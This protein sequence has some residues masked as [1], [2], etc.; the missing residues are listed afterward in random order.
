[1]DLRGVN[2]TALHHPIDHLRAFFSA[3]IWD[4]RPAEL[5]RAKAALFRVSRLGYSTVRGFL[6]NQL[7]V[8]AAA[9]TYYS[10]LSV[11]PFLAFAFAVLKGFGAYRTFIDEI[12]RP[13]LADTF[14][15]NPALH[16][17]TER[18]LEF[19]ERTDV[20]R[21]GALGLVVLVYTSVSL[22]S[23]IEVAL[24]DVFGAKTTRPFLRQITDYVTLLVTTPILVFAAATMSTAAQSSSVIVFLREQLRL[25]PAIDF[26]LGFTPVA[27]VCLALFAMYTILPN[28]RVRPLSALL[29]AAVA[30]LGWQGGL[31]LHVQLQMGVA[32][33]NA[34]YSVLSALPIFLVWSYV[35]WL[36][37]L[38]GAEIAASHQNEQIV[39]QRLRGKRADQA[40]KETLAVAAAAQIARD[41]LAGGP[42]RS[43]AELAA[44]LEVPPPVVEEILEA[45]VRAGL[46]VRAAVA[47]HVGYVP[48]RDLDDIRASDLRDALRREPQAEEVRAVVERRLGPEL[49][50]LIHAHEDERRSSPLNAT[51][52]EL[53]A[54]AP[55]TRPVAPPGERDGH[56]ALAE[57][58]EVLDAKQPETPA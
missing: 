46:L 54:V 41:F 24:N 17:A 30:A 38:V 57:G 11:V 10:I 21:L 52:R 47:Q 37:V 32:K 31:V 36:I 4:A 44:L 13:Y 9:L 33:Y 55:E 53:A 28:V 25:G 14:G 5:P 22:V 50:R 8:R 27:V 43:A 12:V 40:L 45:L 35:S 29:G 51:L 34:L 23:S 1:M 56:P 20:S 2:A 3:R 58:A 26:A 19:V 15:A 18:I 16:Q 48:G 6:D 49:Q 7:T 42:R 39:R